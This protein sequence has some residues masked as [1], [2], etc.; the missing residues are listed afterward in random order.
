MKLTACAA[1]LLLVVVTSAAWAQDKSRPRAR[2]PVQ[3]GASAAGGSAAAERAF[4]ALDR[5]H[6]GYLTEDELWSRNNRARNWIAIDRNGDQRISPDEFSML[7][8]PRGAAA[9]G[10]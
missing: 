1:A 2:A 8:A 3:P 4:R 5:N 7:T 10:R 6:D 9:A